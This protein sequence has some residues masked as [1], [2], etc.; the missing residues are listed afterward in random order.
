MWIAARKITP[1]RD[2][3]AQPPEPI[4]RLRFSSA[5]VRISGQTTSWQYGDLHRPLP[6]G[7]CAA[8]ALVGEG[9]EGEGAAR[10]SPRCLPVAERQSPGALPQ[11]RHRGVTA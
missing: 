9:V 3:T 7:A 11:T 1:P 6:W 4:M 2:W 5:P 8:G 10:T